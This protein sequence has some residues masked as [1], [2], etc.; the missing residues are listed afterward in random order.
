MFSKALLT[1]TYKNGKP[2]QRTEE[3]EKAEHHPFKTQFLFKNPK[4]PKNLYI[5]RL[6]QHFFIIQALETQLQNMPVSDKAKLNTF[7]T[8]SY[9]NQLWRTPAIEK[10]LH[11]LGAN[12]D[13]LNNELKSKTTQIYLNNIESLPP[14]ILLAHFL[15]HV[16]GFMHGGAIIQSKYIN[17]S[18]RLTAYQIPANQY[19]FSAATLF[20]SPKKQAVLELYADMMKQVDEIT[21][22]DREYEEVVQ[23][24][25]D[26]YTTMT[27]IYEDLCALHLSQSKR[28]SPSALMIGISLGALAGVITLM[29]S[30]FTPWNNHAFSPS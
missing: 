3:H 30:Y 22:D 15:L 17:P 10:D 28:F 20:I 27:Q 9:L 2:G 8:L 14:K 26:I 13:A 7:F 6:L 11:Q 1:S 29:S 16:V 19:D 12:N 21:L 18:N 25:L 5:V 24:C 4:I 23:Q